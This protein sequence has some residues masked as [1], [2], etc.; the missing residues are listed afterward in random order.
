MH[1]YSNT[2]RIHLRRYP[3]WHKDGTSTQDDGA[4]YFQLHP[5]PG[6]REPCYVRISALGLALRAIYHFANR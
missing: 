5:D 3:G 2:G 4:E 6:H 1:F